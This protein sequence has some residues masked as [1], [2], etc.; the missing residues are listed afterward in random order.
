MM[1]T[2]QFSNDRDHLEEYGE[3]KALTVRER[4]LG[5][6]LVI[7]IILITILLSSQ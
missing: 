6:L 2:Q 4:T 1:T 5:H 3:S 7:A